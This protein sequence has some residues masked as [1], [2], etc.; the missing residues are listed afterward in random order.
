MLYILMLVSSL[1]L[2]AFPICLIVLLISLLRKKNRK[3]SA[4]L[5]LVVFIIL[6]GSIMALSPYRDT[7]S[8]AKVTDQT[9]KTGTIPAV[10]ITPENSVVYS[11]AGIE[12]TY[13]KVQGT[14]YFQYEVSNS[15]QGDIQFSIDAV[16][17]NGCI[18]N[19]LGAMGVVTKGNKVINK[20]NLTGSEDYSIDKV[21]TLDIYI[22]FYE[23]ETYKMID[24]S[25]CH[26]DVEESPKYNYNCKFP[27]F[28]EDEYIIAYVKQDGEKYENFEVVY[29]NKSDVVLSTALTEV[30]I[31]DVMLS[32]N[33]KG[34]CV[35]PGCYAY[36][37]S[38][39]GTITL[40]DA[41]VS[42]IKDKGLEPIKKIEG[43]LALWGEVFDYGYKTTEDLLICSVE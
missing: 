9:E 6:I 22:V 29:Y 37:G 41:I 26:I 33:I 38:S 18:V 43:K 14:K 25:I 42:E 32:Y 15:G 40:W 10:Q 7:D 16:A 34:A 11:K 19:D 13:I 27:V 24:K 39:K 20:Y 23:R 31:N 36:T 30:A 1:S 12:V 5:L 4:M 35:L 3:M 21:E 2:V 28:Y 17:V 8:T